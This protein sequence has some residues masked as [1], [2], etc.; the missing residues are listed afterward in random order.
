MSNAAAADVNDAGAIPTLAAR[1][2]GRG[3]VAGEGI[4]SA[5]SISV[6]TTTAWKKGR[7]LKGTAAVAAAEPL[8][9]AHKTPTMPLGALMERQVLRRIKVLDSIEAANSRNEVANIWT[10][11]YIFHTAIPQKFGRRRPSSLG[12]VTTLQKR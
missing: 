5:A 8:K 3:A 2:S 11:S 9:T 7:K 4:E 1:R 10:L 6:P 12:D